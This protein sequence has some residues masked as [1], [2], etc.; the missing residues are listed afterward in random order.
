MKRLGTVLEAQLKALPFQPMENLDNL[1]P[2]TRKL[3][4]LNLYCNMFNEQKDDKIVGKRQKTKKKSQKKKAPRWKPVSKPGNEHMP[5]C[6][7]I[8]CNRRVS[9]ARRAK[10]GRCQSG[11]TTVLADDDDD[12]AGWGQF[13]GG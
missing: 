5:E 1:D 2:L 11:K 9:D 8:G 6:T 12:M 13:Y 7:T 3:T 10:C 4:L